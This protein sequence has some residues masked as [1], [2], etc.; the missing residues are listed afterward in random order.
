MQTKTTLT[1]YAVMH[2]DLEPLTI[3]ILNQ[4]QSEVWMMIRVTSRSHVDKVIENV[5]KRKDV[6][7]QF[8]DLYTGWTMN[9]ITK[10]SEKKI[11]EMKMIETT[12]DIVN[13]YYEMYT[14][15]II[16]R[17]N[18]YIMRSQE[19]QKPYIALRQEKKYE[20]MKSGKTN[21][22]NT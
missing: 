13:G 15:G 18:C 22:F 20:S 11:N 8:H 16:N 17:Y 5:L 10:L 14:T 12:E 2:P 4:S 6:R 19:Y 7:Q 9:K 3:A 1:N 21:P